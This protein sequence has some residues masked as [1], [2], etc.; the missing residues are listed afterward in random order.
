MPQVTVT[1]AGKTYRMA[2][3]EGEE[4]HLEGLAASFDARIGDMRK[5]FGE[6]GDMRLHVMAALTLADE[7]AETKRRMEAMERETAALRE[8]SDAGTA[9]REGAEAR[10]AETVQRTAERIER[11]AKRLGS[12]PGGAQGN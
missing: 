1:I 12:A 7:L 4:R 11:L 8:S 10:L 9:E 6:I 5:A 3:G 2:C